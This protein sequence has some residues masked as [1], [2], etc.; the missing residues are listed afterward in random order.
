[1]SFPVL[2]RA[3]F[4]LSGDLVLIGITVLGMPGDRPSMCRMY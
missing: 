3:W 2:V 4:D 1:M